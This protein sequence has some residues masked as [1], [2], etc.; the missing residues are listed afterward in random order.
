MNII[1]EIAIW[2]ALLLAVG[3]LIGEIR[4][5][6]LKKNTKYKY[7]NDFVSLRVLSARGSWRLAQ[8]RMMDKRTF[9]ILRNA[10][11]SKKL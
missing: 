9:A 6:Y 10:E 8:G 1:I 11:Y 4:Y 5:R 7:A 2:V 3:I